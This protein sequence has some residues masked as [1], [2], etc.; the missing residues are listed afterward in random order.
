MDQTD[1]EYRR[2]FL[3]LRVAGFDAG[4]GTH[5][6]LNHLAHRSSSARG[7]TPDRQ[8]LLRAVHDQFSL[9]QANPLT[10]PPAIARGHIGYGRD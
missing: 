8:R 9:D 6:R 3:Y 10:R 5:A 1:T 7:Q 2:A 4:P